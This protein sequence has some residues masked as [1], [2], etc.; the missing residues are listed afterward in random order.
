[1]L[2]KIQSEGWISGIEEHFFREILGKREKLKIEPKIENTKE[3]IEVQKAKPK[4]SKR[5]ISIESMP[6]A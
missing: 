6:D 3:T 4:K 5:R 1:M 2:A